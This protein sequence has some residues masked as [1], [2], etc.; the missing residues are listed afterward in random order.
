VRKMQRREEWIYYSN[1]ICGTDSTR[2]LKPKGI[3]SIREGRKIK[4]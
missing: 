4:G 2:K 1:S 3:K